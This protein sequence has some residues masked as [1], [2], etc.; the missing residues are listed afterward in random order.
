MRLWKNHSGAEKAV[1][2]RSSLL[3]SA[4][5][6]APRLRS[7]LR[8]RLRVC[9]ALPGLACL[10]AP[11]SACLRALLVCVFTCPALF[12]V[13]TSLCM[14]FVCSSV[15]AFP[16]LR[17]CLAACPCVCECGRPPA[18]SHQPGAS[19]SQRLQLTRIASTAPIERPV[20][21]SLRPHRQ[22]RGRRSG[23]QLAASAQLL[24][25]APEGGREG[26]ACLPAPWVFP[27]S[28]CPGSGSL[29]SGLCSE[30]EGLKAQPGSSDLTPLACPQRSL[31]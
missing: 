24:A 11:P 20:D 14:F 31:A 2:A 23:P 30:S 19:H 9:V 26:L 6:R 25:A 1:A 8:S 27:G 15:S 21:I 28:E 4:C 22:R 5:L 18:S 12:C 10:R 16:L 13:H 3:S 7:S 29:H 17:W